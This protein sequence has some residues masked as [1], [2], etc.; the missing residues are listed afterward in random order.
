MIADKCLLR[1]VSRGVPHLLQTLS[2][3]AW[4]RFGP[5]SRALVTTNP[6][7][8]YGTMDEQ[9]PTPILHCVVER[10]RWGTASSFTPPTAASSVTRTRALV[11]Q[12]DQTA[13]TA[14]APPP[15]NTSRWDAVRDHIP[16]SAT[17]T[18]AGAGVEIIGRQTAT[19]TG[20][21]TRT[22]ASV[23]RHA[24]VVV[25]AI[26]HGKQSPEATPTTVTNIQLRRQ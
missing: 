22:A 21:P 7:N 1:I 6:R 23:V 20:R 16:P 5:L 11:G 14:A 3:P 8:L 13:A 24:I 12:C 25:V 10:E 18:T 19:K 26:C 4:I 9:E 17:N 15:C 2:V